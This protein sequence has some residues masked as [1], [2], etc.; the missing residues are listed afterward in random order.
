M[1]E[2]LDNL[3]KISE[4]LRK[5][6]AQIKLIT[7]IKKAKQEYDKYDYSS[8]IK[9]LEEAY[10]ISPKNSVVLRGLGCMY[11]FNKDY[12]KALEY[13]N[14]ALTYS[15]SKEI[16]YTFIGM[17]YYLQDKLDEAVVNFNKAIDINDNYPNAYEGRNQAL[18]ENHIKILDLQESL[19]K[20]F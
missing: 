13:F 4:F 14:K 16:E 7:L 1:E 12:E 5:S 18:L 19:K 10:R 8:G 9:T 15:E 11:Q 17:I 20:Y 6:S 2:I 3:G